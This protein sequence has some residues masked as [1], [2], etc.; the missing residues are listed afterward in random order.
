MAYFRERNNLRAEYSGHQQIS[1]SLRER[2]KTIVSKYSYGYYTDK[3]TLAHDLSLHLGN[4][5]INDIL[6]QSPYDYVLEAIEILLHCIKADKYSVRSDLI[7]AFNLSGSVYQVNN[8]DEVYLRADKI[9]VE[10]LENIK[11]PLSRVPTAYE[12][13]FNAV[14]SL[15]GMKA[16]PKD[17]VGDIFIG[18]EDYLKNITGAKKY[19]EAISKLEKDKIIASPQKALLDKIQAYRGDASGVAH[20]GNS[21]EPD[22]IDAL[23]YL[24]TVIAQIKLIDNRMR[25]ST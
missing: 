17:I 19:G 16:A 15:F 3:G 11:E 6:S 12:T 18:F 7:V 4:S 14:G 23:W 25:P 20:P 8:R 9:T 1:N 13:F 10:E 24:N 2:L 5:S 21:R 22:E